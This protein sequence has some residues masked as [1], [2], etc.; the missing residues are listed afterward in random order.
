MEEPRWSALMNR[1]GLIS[2]HDMPQRLH[3]DHANAQLLAKGLA[4]IPGIELDPDVVHTNIIVFDLAASSGW[5]P[6]QLEAALK[7]REV[8]PYC[9]MDLRVL[10]VSLI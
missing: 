10:H 2:L 8:I 5:S 3:E 9:I 6:E 7:V 4:R 1:A